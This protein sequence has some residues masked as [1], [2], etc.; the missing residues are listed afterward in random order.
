MLRITSAQINPTIGDISGNVALMLRAARQAGDE[1]ADLV[2]FPEMSLTAYYPGDLLDDANFQARVE[3]GLV[4]L[5]LATRET[6]Q[7]LW[8]VG[9]PVR[10]TG[11]GKP[12]HNAL[13][14]LQNGEVLLHY[15]KQL[16][17]TYNI[18]DERRHFEPGP[19]VARVLRI[20]DAQVGLMICEDGWNDDGQDY[21]VNPF[22]RLTLPLIWWCPSTPA[23]AMWANASSA[24]WCFPRP[25]CATVCPWCM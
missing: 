12:F 14:V 13:L 17:P 2:V 18:F 10:R 11:I 4:Q 24:I 9:A 5:K 16:L 21:L 3:A 23:P 15:A 7:V 25:V 19:D 20:R 6:P 1:H 8:V 22:Q